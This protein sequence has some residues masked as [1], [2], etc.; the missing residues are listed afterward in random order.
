MKDAVNTIYRND[1]QPPEYLITK[2]DLDFQ[3]NEAETIVNA[4]LTMFRNLD[5]AKNCPLV[6]DGEALELLAIEL[7]H[8][9]LASDRYQVTETGLTVFDLPDQFTLTTKVRIKPQENTALQ[10]LYKSSGNFCTQCEAQGFRR[11]TYYLDRPDVMASFIT[12]I[13]ADKELYPVLLSNGN[14]IDQGQSSDNRHWVKWQDPFKKP[15]YLFA[16][17]AGNLVEIKDTFI[18]QSGREVSLKIFVQKSNESK[19]DHAMQ[20]LKK[21]MRW[22]EE[23][24]GREYDLDI[25]MIV[26]VDDFN[27]GAMENKGLN[28][29]NSKCILANNQT[30]TDNDFTLIAQ[31]V[32]HEYFHNWTGNR[33]TCR[34]WFQLSLKEGLTVYRDQEF[35][36]DIT[37]RATKRIDD[38]AKLRSFQFPQD[39]GPM[40][41]SVRPDSYMEISN[42]YTTTIY[43][44]GAEVI[45]MQAKLLGKDGFRKGMDLYFQ[46]HDG[47]A[48]TCDDFVKAMEDANDYDL[49]QFKLWYA[50]AGTPEITVVRHY[51]DEQQ[52]YQLTFTQMIPDTPGQPTKKPMHIPIEIALLD[53][54]GQELLLNCDDQM[55]GCTS[56]VLSLRERTQTFTFNNITE[57]PIPS[58]LRGFTAPAN[59]KHDLTTDELIFLMT[60]D[61][62]TFTRYASGQQLATNIMLKL[63]TNYQAG[64]TLQIDSKFV[65]AIKGILLDEKVDK[66]YKAKAIELPNEIDLASQMTVVD[67]SAIHHVRKFMQKAIANELQDEFLTLYHENKSLGAYQYLTPAIAKRALKASCLHYL[68]QLDLKEIHQLAANQFNEANNMSDSITALAA[69]ASSSYTN[70]EQVLETFYKKWHTD[71]LV[72]D[73]W[74]TVQATADLPNL[75]EK[76]RKLVKHPAFNLANPNK[77]RSIFGAFSLYNFYHFHQADGSGY[78]FLTDYM[79]Q[80]DAKNPQTA[81]RLIEPL[82]RWQRLEPIRQKLMQ[83]QL[84]RILKSDTISKDMYEMV[85]KSLA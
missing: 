78:Q 80:L 81:A 69:I 53:Q 25:F 85:S 19:C 16:L 29:F 49:S 40:A 76:L 64:L 10:G 54:N 3:L 7:D 84:Q 68:M 75:V 8:Q 67:P 17:V 32:G 23:N 31:V 46:R 59:L 52:T 1:Y 43:E 36:A 58:L 33:V 6:L 70:R 2:V 82:T 55:P 5:T 45:R 62:D 83:E 18:T 57:N 39:A 13:E 74:F 41:H 56:K 14:L 72:I 61:Q 73:K 26:A 15:S 35:T 22:D 63:I 60:H 12:R 51:N 38:V 24:F 27:M 50:Q 71:N 77:A 4:K 48:V 79:L 65:T 21:A 34:D 20:S 28:I 66:L 11:I 47:Q 42:F 37:S 30:S 44:K 9:K